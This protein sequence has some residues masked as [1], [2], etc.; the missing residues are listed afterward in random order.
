MKHLRH[1]LGISVLIALVSTAG[2]QP[3]PYGNMALIPAGSFT[4]GD[5]LDGESDA[6]PVTANTSAFYMDTNSVS[7]SQWDDVYT[8]AITHGYTFDNVG[9]GKAA[10]HPVQTINWW[11]SVKWCNARSEKE[12]RI[13]AYYTDAGSTTVYRSGQVSPYVNWTAG[14]R[15][16]TEAEW[17]KAARGGLIGQRFPWGNTISQSQA[18]YYGDTAFTYDS[19]P[20]G[21]NATYATG[22]YP[23]TSPI[24]SFA[25][26]AYGLF[27]MAGN[28]LQ[29]C[30][31]WYGT[32]YAGG[33]DPR[34]AASGSVRVVRGG[35]WSGTPGDC[36]AANRDAYDMTVSSF[37]FGFRSVLNAPTMPMI[38]ID[39]TNLSP[40][41]S[42]NASFQVLAS[43]LGPFT[44]QWFYTNGYPLATAGAYA[45]PFLP[46][47]FSAVVTNGGFG[48]SS[49]PNVRF[50][51]GG[52][53]GILAYTT[54]TN[55][56]VQSITITNIGGGYSAPPT[57]IIDPPS[58][59]A[60]QTNSFLTISNVG[61][62]NLG[63]YWV[64][65][66]NSYGSVTSSVANL[67]LL[68]P[69]TIA[70][71]PVSQSLA[72]SG[73]TTLS[74]TVAG[75]PPFSY[76]WTLA[77]T[78]LPSATNSTLA[79]TNFSLGQVGSYAV[80]VT[81][82]YGSAVSSS[83]QVSILPSIN[84]PFKT[85]V[86]V[87]AASPALI[88]YGTAIPAIGYTTSPSTVPGDWT[89]EPNCAVYAV[90]DTTYATPL[91]GA[92]IA[93]GAY[94]TH[95]SGG[96][97]SK[98][99][100]TSYVD[101]TFVIKAVVSVTAASPASISYGT[102]IPAIGYTTSP[103][104]VPGDWTVEPNCAV[105]AVSD[106]T[107]AT[108]LTGASIAPGTYVTH[109]FGGTSSE[110][111]P[112]SYVDGTFVIT[113]AVVSVTAASPASI[114]YGT[115]IPAIGYTTS[116]STV[117]GDWT[118]EPNCAV[119]AVSDTTYSTPLWGTSIAPGTYVTHCFGGFSS[120]YNPTSYVDGTFVIK[121][122]V[123]VPLLKLEFC[124][125]KLDLA[126][127]YLQI[128]VSG[129]AGKAVVIESSS[130][131]IFWHSIQT[132]TVT[133]EVISINVPI[134]DTPTQFYRALSIP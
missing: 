3:Q 30:W 18:N 79:L 5:T 55:G 122:V 134:N 82:P 23:Y 78:N 44:Y 68:Y 103:S 121:A 104:T 2:A 25:P 62:S 131:L 77:G 65:I 89:V 98:Y 45:Q 33:T 105:Y 106:T 36:R 7:K 127:G 115:A 93:P 46:F 110:Y 10:N 124:N 66:A 59:L 15:L 119:Y 47:V 8:W 49:A 123:S 32:P 6:V 58:L 96:T 64:V 48:Y 53:S 67:T 118:S 11:D 97:S 112:T 94:V 87:T 120:E 133:T 88:S 56:S 63:S 81:S 16:P 42:S 72:L 74:V 111:N 99:K 60:G 4:M 125:T 31:D 101:G 41:V 80:T 102:A 85:D 61:P 24:G 117:P 86:T 107:Y 19:G 76:Q 113:Q 39:L 129:C 71:P 75:T 34:G 116:P 9:S 70:V 27:D 126:V 51:G 132:N 21:Y 20:N 73:S 29:W 38:S 1:L 12:N 57:V 84:A 128:Q 92:S 95:C 50:V 17:E 69:P 28:V 35:S 90:S 54:V 130:D 100:P 13:P 108:P 109:C 40:V 22:S 26:N 43:G 91:T 52:G 83:A 114:F 14:Y 37:G